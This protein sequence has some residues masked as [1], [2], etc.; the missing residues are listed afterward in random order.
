MVFMGIFNGLN[1]K[2]MLNTTIGSSQESLRG[3]LLMMKLRVGETSNLFA[4]ILCNSLANTDVRAIE[5]KL[6]GSIESTGFAFFC[7]VIII[8]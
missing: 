8:A 5:Q 1:R 2:F 7:N 3:D 6:E 4:S